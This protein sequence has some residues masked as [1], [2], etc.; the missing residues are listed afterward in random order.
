MGEEL[1][2]SS[3]TRSMREAAPRA[4]FGLRIKQS[5]VE[6]LEILAEDRGSTRNGLI[7]QAIEDF[8]ATHFDEEQEDEN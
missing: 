3:R 8:L 7:E 4:L 6:K 5:L 1:P 2:Q